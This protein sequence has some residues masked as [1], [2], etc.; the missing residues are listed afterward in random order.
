MEVVTAPRP[1]RRAE[2]NGAGQAAVLRRARLRVTPQRV[3]VLRA[4]AAGPHLATCQEIWERARRDAAGL[5]QVTVYRILEKLAAVGVIERLHVNG[6]TQFGL[7]IRHHDHAIC[8]RCGTV[9]ATERCLLGPIPARPV[10]MH[11]F[12]VKRHRVDLI[13]LCVACQTAESTP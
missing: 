8:E 3:A 13:G 11:G 12:L 6:T 10:G 9:V 1:L 5:G 4:L 2:P 7:A